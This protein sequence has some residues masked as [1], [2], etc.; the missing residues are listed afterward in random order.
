MAVHHWIFK[1]EPSDY[2]WSDLVREQRTAW[3]GV[4]NALAQQHLRSVAEDDDVLIYHTGTERT[5]VGLARAASAPYPD[6]A[7]PDGKCVTLDLVPVRPLAH[8]VTLAAIKEDAAF[9]DLALVRMGRLSVVP[10]T[11]AQW[12]RLMELASG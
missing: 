3:T 4:R 9:K 1:T 2:S 6:P 5:A 10:V 8:P 7:A 12:K 11:P